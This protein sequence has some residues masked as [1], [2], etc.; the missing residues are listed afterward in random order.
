MADGVRSVPV[1]TTLAGALAQAV[2]ARRSAETAARAAGID[3]DAGLQF[4]ELVSKYERRIFN[5]IFRM[6]GD[7]EDACDLTQDTFISA[8]RHYDRFRGEARVFT[9]L[10]Q[11]A[12]NLCI[13][14][15]RQR[16]RHRLMRIESLD[17]PAQA[18]SSGEVTRDV[19]DSRQAPHTV[20][21][22][23]E[24]NA[25]IMAAIDTLPPEYREVIVLREF[26]DMT[27]ADIVE[28]TG[29]TLENVKTRISRA[30][31]MLRRELTSYYRS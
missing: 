9:W 26:Q 7:Y 21:A 19:P 6:V 11:I 2:A 3:V 8:Y 27:Y 29:L 10:Y 16:D 5:I 4:D 1:H 18:D 15:L 22:R 30:R 14:R 31:A 12:R 17:Q 24:L 20:L 28:A 23:K 25:Q 13:N